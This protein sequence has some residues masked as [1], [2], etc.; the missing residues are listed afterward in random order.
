MG[1]LDVIFQFRKGFSI[2]TTFQA[3]V[4]VG[5]VQ[6]LQ[7]SMQDV[8]ANKKFLTDMTGLR[9]KVSNH[10][11]GFLGIFFQNGVCLTFFFN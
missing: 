1:L 4:R 3:F 11:S 2:E 6:G 8:L 10:F 5:I 7:M 9:I